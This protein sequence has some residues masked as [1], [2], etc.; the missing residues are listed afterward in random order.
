MIFFS[1]K[2]EK[3]AANPHGGDIKVNVSDYDISAP[4]LTEE[5]KRRKQQE[6]DRKKYGYNSYTAST[7]E[8]TYI[9]DGKICHI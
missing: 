4:K 3:S 2:K 1:S 6:E 9:E 7:S 5:L 8:L